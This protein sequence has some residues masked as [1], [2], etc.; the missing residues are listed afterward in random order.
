MVAEAHAETEP[1][2]L[3]AHRLRVAREA[4]LT[5]EQAVEFAESRA[6]IGMLRALADAGCDPDLIAR[7]VL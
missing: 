4:G 5:P 7:I 6:D 2:R 1:L 3:L